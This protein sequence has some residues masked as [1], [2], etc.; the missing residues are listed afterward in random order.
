[1]SFAVRVFSLGVNGLLLGQLAWWCTGAKARAV[2]RCRGG[3]MCRRSLPVGD[4]PSGSCRMLR[5][6]LSGASHAATRTCS[7][8][9]PLPLRSP[10]RGYP[11]CVAIPQP[12]SIG[13]ALGIAR[14][15]RRQSA[16]APNLHPAAV[17][18]GDVG[19]R[20]AAPDHAAATFTGHFSGRRCSSR[21]NK[22]I[23]RR[24]WVYG[25]S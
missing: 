7:G 19:I 22:D 6:E 9:L 21:H 2:P 13:R 10:L 23:A 18:R 12:R 8:N 4:D 24:A 1:M 14:R 11:E 25:Q 3:Q 5:Q 20:S 16:D 17:V 15:A